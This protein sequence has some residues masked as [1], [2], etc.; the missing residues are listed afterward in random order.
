MA[1]AGV[2]L[3]AVGV[4]DPQRRPPPGWAGA[5]ARDDH[6]RSL[7]DDVTTE[8]DPRRPGELEANPGRLADRSRESGL[9]ALLAAPAGRPGG[10]P[11]D[12]RRL[13]DDQGDVRPPGERR[14][15]R[16]SIAESR[17]RAALSRAVDPLRRQVDDEQVDR[18]TREQRAG[19]RQPF[20]RVRGR[21]HDQPLRLD[22][23]GHGLDRVE[24]CREVQPGHDGARGLGLRD[25]PQRQRRPPARD[26]ATHRQPHPARHATGSQDRIELGE[27]GRVNPVRVGHRCS[28]RPEVGGLEWHRCEGAH[29]LAGEPGR[30]RAPA[31][32]KGRQRRGQVGRRSTHEAQYRT[33]VRMNQAP[34]S[35][36][37]AAAVPFATY[38]ANLTR[39][40]T[41]A[42]LN[43]QSRP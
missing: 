30:R 3:P 9:R 34:S 19:D 38:A 23:A 40:T 29:D 1:K 7:A 41:P 22:A 14:D 33:N 20:L 2:A 15:P 25:E 32:S 37:H 39:T 18:P 6:L 4:E 16:E 10:R 12:R 36:S 17:S 28:E 31:R 21:Q 27:A 43:A 11:G 24:R 42:T 35:P 26:V 8:P 13:E 5:I